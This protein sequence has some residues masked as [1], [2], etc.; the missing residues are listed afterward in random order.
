MNGKKRG[1]ETTSMMFFFSLSESPLPP[2]L[3]PALSR[4][5]EPSKGDWLLRLV[6]DP[7]AHTSQ[8][9]CPARSLPSGRAAGNHRA[10][11]P[12]NVLALKPQTSSSAIKT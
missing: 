3:S 11:Q 9:H 10:P 7:C 4:L 8:E 1:Y 6:A 2:S 5:H 12:T